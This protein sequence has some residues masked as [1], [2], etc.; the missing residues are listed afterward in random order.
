MIDEVERGEDFIKAKF[1]KALNSDDLPSNVRE[2]VSRAYQT[3]RADHDQI[4]AM[5]HSMH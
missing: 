2:V 5:K 4:S 3:I 1:E